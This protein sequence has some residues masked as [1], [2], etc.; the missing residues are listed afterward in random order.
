M[1]D[2]VML[3]EQPNVSSIEKYMLLRRKG[4]IPI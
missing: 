3:V 1:N 4:N 2:L